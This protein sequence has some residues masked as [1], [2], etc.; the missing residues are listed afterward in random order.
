M[1][2]SKILGEIPKT[3]GE[4][5]K[6]WAFLL[7]KHFFL[8]PKV[9]KKVQWKTFRRAFSARLIWARRVSAP[10][11]SMFAWH[12]LELERIFLGQL[13][14]TEFHGSSACEVAIIH[15]G[16][17]NYLHGSDH[18]CTHTVDNQPVSCPHIFWSFCTRWRGLSSSVSLQS[19]LWM[20][21]TWNL[22]ETILRTTT[23]CH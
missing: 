18:D 1:K 19:H 22:S 9:W 12:F 23:P 11:L 6:H 2:H 16:I 14:D 3:L 20:S 8:P 17:W 4:T 21:L 15:A 10:G 13:C 5:L 7:V